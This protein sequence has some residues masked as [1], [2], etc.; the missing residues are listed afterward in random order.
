MLNK[1][2]KYNHRPP[3]VEPL[4]YIDK[5]DWKKFN[6]SPSPPKKTFRLKFK[7][8]E[9]LDT[10]SMASPSPLNTVIGDGRTFNHN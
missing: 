6:K 5:E 9:R 1:F 7:I 2:Q 8:P 10:N 4:D 3:K